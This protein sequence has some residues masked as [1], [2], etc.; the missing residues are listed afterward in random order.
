MASAAKNSTAGA[1]CMPRSCWDCSAGDWAFTARL[2]FK[3]DSRN[4]RLVVWADLR[5]YQRAFSAGRN[6]RRKFT[7][8]APTLWR[9]RRDQNRRAVD[10]RWHHGLGPCKRA[11][12][13]FC[14]RRFERHRL[15]H[16]ERRSTQRRG[17]AVVCSYT[18]R[19]ARHGVQRWQRRRHYFLA[20]LGVRH[21]RRGVSGCRRCD[22][23]CHG[24]HAV[25]A[26][27]PR[28]FA[29]TGDHGATARW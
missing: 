28:V 27:R 25:A 4:T 23:H 11:V 18:P 26:G 24:G 14:C 12:A 17:V 21:Q 15:G 8:I 9:E 2:F 29:H 3:R 7:R 20:A 13:T 16:D 5:R 1:S 19:R 6:H 10:G 22:Y